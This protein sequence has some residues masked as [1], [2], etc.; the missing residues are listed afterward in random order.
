[1]VLIQWLALSLA[2]VLVKMAI[3]RGVRKVLPQIMQRLD[4]E[5]PTWLKEGLTAERVSGRV[6]Q[7]IG[8]LTGKPVGAEQVNAVMRIFDVRMAVSRAAAFL[9]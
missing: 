3:D 7:A 2:D 1:M 9:R 8:D 4:D 6:A 5:L